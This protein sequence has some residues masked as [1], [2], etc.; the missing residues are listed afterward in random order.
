[1]KTEQEILSELLIKENRSIGNDLEWA[2]TQLEC[3]IGGQ[4]KEALKKGNMISDM[5]ELL[6]EEKTEDASP[7]E[8][9]AWR[10]AV[11]ECIA[12]VEYYTKYIKV[13]K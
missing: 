7:D 12:I 10:S 3:I 9:R 6:S 4:L 13:R 2:N 11:Q 5:E 8:A 1:M